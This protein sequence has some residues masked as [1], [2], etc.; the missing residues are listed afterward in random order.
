M[1]PRKLGRRSKAA[2]QPLIDLVVRT[3]GQ[4]LVLKSKNE[5]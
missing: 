1:I 2:E 4:L 3:F 5:R